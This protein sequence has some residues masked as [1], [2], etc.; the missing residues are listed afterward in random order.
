MVDGTHAELRKYLYCI[1]SQR[2]GLDFSRPHIIPQRVL[3]CRGIVRR[4]CEAAFRGYGSLACKDAETGGFTGFTF[5]IYH[6]IEKLTRALLRT[7]P[8]KYPQPSTSIFFA[9]RME[10]SSLFK[11]SESLRLTSSSRG[12]K[13]TPH[14][15]YKP[16]FQYSNISELR[17]VCQGEYILWHANPEHSYI[18]GEPQFLEGWLGF[19]GTTTGY[20]IHR[21]RGFFL[22]LNNNN[23][24]DLY[25]ASAPDIRS[26]HD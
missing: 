1:P 24:F 10:A 16:R 23:K 21:Y 12:H 3:R 17:R 2:Y 8:P 15:A 9:R 22:F 6:S 13:P 11:L 14:D 7:C 19:R 25:S 4:G 5:Q 20:I 18:M 26:D